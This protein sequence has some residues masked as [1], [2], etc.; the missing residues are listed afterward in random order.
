LITGT[1]ECFT[2]GNDIADF[3]QQPPSAANR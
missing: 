3:I 2:A 1:T